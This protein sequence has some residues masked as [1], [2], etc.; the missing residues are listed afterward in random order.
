[1]RIKNIV[2]GIKAVAP[3]ITV[4]PK[5]VI[6]ISSND[7]AEAKAAEAATVVDDGRAR[8]MKAAVKSVVAEV[9]TSKATAAVEIT[10]AKAASPCQPL[11]SPR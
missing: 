4:V 3:S 1:L 9:S 6:E 5:V 11:P 10:A 7:G 8:V 2:V